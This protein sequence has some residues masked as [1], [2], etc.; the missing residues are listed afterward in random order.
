MF[1]LNSSFLALVTR[2]YNIA[3]G[4]SKYCHQTMKIKDITNSLE[5]LAPVSYQE[6]Y[7]NCGLLV[8]DLDQ[9]LQ[10]V[11]ITLDTTEAVV[12]EAIEVGANLIVMHHPLIFKGLKSITNSHWVSRCVMKAIRNDISLYAIHTNLDNVKDGVNRKI[13]EKLGLQDI[14]ILRPKSGNLMKLVTFI[15][16]DNVQDA[17]DAMYEAGAGEVGEYDHCSFQIEGM[18]TFRPGEKTDPHIGSQG[19]DETV[20][21]KR[22]EILFPGHIKSRVMR[23]LNQAHPYEE[24]AHYLTELSNVNQDVGSGMIGNLPEPRDP[25]SFISMLKSNMNTDCV[26]H[27]SWHKSKVERI[28]VCG[29]SGSFLLNDAVAKNVDVMVSADFKY[30]DFF[31]ADDRIT[32]ADIGHYES[33]QFT[34]ELLYDF[35]KEKFTNIAVLL[36]KVV[37]NPIIYS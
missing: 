12:D 6:S 23:A 34:K 2:S 13:C 15:P 30:H 33:E 1:R 26:R 36:S 28:A 5:E 32:I 17:L 24:V 19:K 10:K 9:N 25:D 18:G 8:G 22:V 14:E 7:D 3:K 16:I 35:L 37:T 27:T 4:N 29:G 21:E 20:K 31:E 11:L